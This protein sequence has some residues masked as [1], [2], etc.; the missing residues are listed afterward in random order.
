MSASWK[1]GRL[2]AF[3]ALAFVLIPSPA[4]AQQF[5]VR[6]GVSGSP[7]Q[8]YLGVHSDI[9]PVADKLRFRPNLEIGFGNDTTLTAINLEFVYPLPLDS[10]RWTI[11]PGIGPAVN[12][13]TRAGTTDVRGGL[14]VLVGLAH[15][16]GFFTEL[17]VGAID[18][19]GVKFGVGYT[20]RR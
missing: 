6:A 1:V 16:D 11:Y 4:Q 13:L 19:P 15:T 20:F 18:S 17:K 9:G 12:I 3:G 8:F 7:E 2:L 14:N 10:S 5:G